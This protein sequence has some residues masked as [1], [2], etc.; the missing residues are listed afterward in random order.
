MLKFLI[1]GVFRD[2]HR[3]LFPLLIVSAGVLIILLFQ[4]FLRGYMG[5]FIRQ[6]SGFETG[7]LKVVTRA[8]AE[9]LSQKPYDLGFVDIQDE[10]KAWS[11]AYPELE[12]AQRIH[13]GALLDV[14]DAAGE[15]REQGEIA[16]FAINIFGLEAER[17][18]MGLAKG[19]AEGRVP[20][21]PGEILISAKALARLKLK[22][23][24]PVTLIGTDANGS[25]A[26]AGFRISGTVR[27]GVE[28]LDRGAVIADISD[29]RAMLDLPGGASEILA[30]FKDGEYN[31]A[32]AT[33]IRDG[34][35][36]RF[37]REVEE[38]SPVMLAM[39]DQN[40]LGFLIAI[41]DGVF[42]MMSIVFIFILGI[43]LWNSGLMNGI[44]RYG[45]FGVRLAVGESKRHLYRSLILEAVIIGVAG[46]L[47]GVL[48]GVAVN[49]YFNLHGLDM[50]V[51][52]RNTTLMTEDIVRTELKPQ[53][54]LA[55]LIPGVLS[56]VLGAALA[57]RAIFSRQ[58][59]Q[60]FKELET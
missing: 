45:E 32:R 37:S 42:G 6:T 41:M 35:N 46:S 5:S 1:K 3:Y 19:L 40:D 25:M 38:F 20:T 56:T 48:L 34:F 51:F 36:A 57:G 60:L 54:A 17:R 2:R 26:M 21:R 33:A 15:T 58:T 31:N 10:L 11:E 28:A 47:I 12:W 23:G 22:L 24:D 13:F 49:W 16:G 14:P 4:A 44:R 39:S 50:S 52:T 55:S 8:Y 29:I 59:S 9:L 43:V 53:D 30:F 27:F 7:H 18:R